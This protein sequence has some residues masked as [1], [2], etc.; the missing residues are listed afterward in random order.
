MCQ[1]KLIDWLRIKI[2]SY[3][4]F[5]KGKCVILIIN[6]FIV[7]LGNVIIFFGRIKMQNILI[8]LVWEGISF[9]IRYRIIL[10]K[11]ILNNSS[12]ASHGWENLVYI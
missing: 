9:Q 7:I 6:K 11:E 10:C 8:L 4:K 1:L 12:R 5:L 2:R 3:D